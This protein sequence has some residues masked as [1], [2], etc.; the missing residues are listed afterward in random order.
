MNIIHRIIKQWKEEGDAQFRRRT[1]SSLKKELVAIAGIALVLLISTGI[2]LIAKSGTMNLYLSELPGTVEAKDIQVISKDPSV[3]T[4]GQVRVSRGKAVITLIAGQ[5]GN[6]T[7]S[8]QTPDITKYIEIECKAFGRLVD[9]STGN[10]SGW[11]AITAAASLFALLSSLILLVSFLRSLKKNLFSYTTIIKLTVQM[12]LSLFGLAGTVLMI[13]F[14]INPGY[15]HF[16]NII[17]FISLAMVFAAI[18]SIPVVIVFAVLLCISNL[19]LIQREGFRV[20]NLLGIVLSGIILL[21]IAG[22]FLLARVVHFGSSFIFAALVNVYFGIYLFFVWTLFSTFILFF[23]LARRTPAYDK[24]C[25]VILGCAIRPDGTLYPLIRGR[26]DKAI[27]FAKA[28]E[29][30]TGKL[31]VFIPSG[32]QGPDEG[33]SEAEAMTDYLIMQGIPAERILP[34]TKATNTQENLMFSR[35]IVE[36]Y[37]PDAKVLFATTNYHVLRSGI[38]SRKNGWDPDGIGSRTR[39][40]FWPNALIREFLG[41][42]VDDIRGVTVF[43]IFVAVISVLVSLVSM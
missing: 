43:A 42:V 18:L 8:I 26:V 38:L 16:T 7:V 3:V 13:I 27:A 29:R 32:G 33:K 36:A 12:A 14:I 40:Y 4:P 31:A 23:T 5:E 11:E 1:H 10:F 35:E 37:Q 9:H 6:S 34:E 24:D 22:G 30:E 19:R 15:Y 21:G 28:Q 20:V 17:H 25:I 2:W 39:W 41:M